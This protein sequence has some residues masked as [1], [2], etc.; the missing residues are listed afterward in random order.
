[1]VSTNFDRVWEGTMSDLYYDR[2]IC[3]NI[4]VDVLYVLVVIDKFAEAKH[5][6]REMKI[7]YP[8]T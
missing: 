8:K 3:K 4:M 1:M 5:L 2:S 6:I 7:V